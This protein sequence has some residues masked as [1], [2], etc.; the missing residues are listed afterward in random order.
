MKVDKESCKSNA[1]LEA[2]ELRTWNFHRWLT[3]GV[4]IWRSLH[5]GHAVLALLFHGFRPAEQTSSLSLSRGSSKRSKSFTS[6]RD[7]DPSN[8]GCRISQD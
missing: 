8:C 2:L 7:L 3:K 6:S 1:A 4:T 5:F